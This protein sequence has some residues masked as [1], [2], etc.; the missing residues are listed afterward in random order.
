[1]SIGNLS[2]EFVHTEKFAE[3]RRS[4]LRHFFSG[5]MLIALLRVLQE[6]SLNR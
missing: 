3:V 6:M 5:F 1:M 2:S 4:E